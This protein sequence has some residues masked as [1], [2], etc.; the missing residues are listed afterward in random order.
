M[1][2]EVLRWPVTPIGLHYLLVH[3]D[4]PVVHPEGWSLEIGGLVA[5]P[6]SLSLADVK[7]LPATAVTVTMECAG[8][9]RAL[10]SPRPRSQPW[11]AEA[12]GTAEWTGTPLGP[13][14]AAC[15]PGPDAV[16]VV[17]TGVDRGVEGGVPQN[18]E[19]SL[20]LVDVIDDGHALLAYEMNGQPLPPQHG[21]PLRLGVPGWYGMASVKWLRRI[22]VVDR[23]FTGYQ[24]AESYRVRTEPGDAGEALGEPGEPVTRMLPRALMVP[25]G[26]PDF[27]TRHRLVRAGPCPLTGRAWSGLGPVTQVEVSTDGGRRWTVAELGPSAGRWAWRGWTFDWA[28]PGP[29]DYVLCCRATDGA[30]NVQPFTPAWNRGGYVN[31]AVQRVAVTAAG[32]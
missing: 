12:V 25:P 22:S 27:Y 29:G 15:E 21:F 30:G 24:M 19:R 6:R 23:P 2:L 13:L 20:P 9:G 4:I 28:P 10:L 17:F 8:N 26:I 7:A 16:E 11:L 5:Q 32:G 3:Y 14:L 18:Y 1:P 31:N